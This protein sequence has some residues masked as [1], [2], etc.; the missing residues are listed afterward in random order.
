[1]EDLSKQ[2][3]RPEGLYETVAKEF[4]TEWNP[5]ETKGVETWIDEMFKPILRKMGIRESV[6]DYFGLAYTSSG[7]YAQLGACNVNHYL[8]ETYYISEFV[9]SSSGDMFIVCNDNEENELIFGVE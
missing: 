1:M 4:K 9:L 5:A 2:I 3:G 6:E 7:K 8:T